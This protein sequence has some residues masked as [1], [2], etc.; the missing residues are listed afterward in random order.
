MGVKNT[1]KVFL[2]NI[3]GRSGAG[4]YVLPSRMILDQIME[5]TDSNGEYPDIIILTEVVRNAPGYQDLLIGLTE[6]EYECKCSKMEKEHNQVLIAVRKKCIDDLNNF[7]SEEIN[8][9]DF[10]NEDAPIASSIIGEQQSIKLI[11]N[12]LKVSFQYG[13]KK[14][15][16]VGC[17]ILP[18]GISKK[19]FDNRAAQFYDVLEPMIKKLQQQDIVIIGGDFNNARYLQNYEGMNQVNYNLHR[20]QAEML[21]L[22]YIELDMWNPTHKFLSE[23]HLFG[24]G[25]DKYNC[26]PYWGFINIKN[27]YKYVN[28]NAY[29]AN[30]YEDILGL[31]DHAIVLCEIEV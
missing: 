6:V 17:R 30:G 28:Y 23:D 24:K 25:L 5:R 18:G 31:P 29:K 21:S 16:I 11:P 12:Y 2:W 14:V 3:N 19:D 22:G 20:I 27:G 13:E 4:N 1:L 15:S 8:A 7:E 10:L 26:K 9:E